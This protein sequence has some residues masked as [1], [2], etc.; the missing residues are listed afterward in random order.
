MGRRWPLTV[1]PGPLPVFEWLI[2][3]LPSSL[4][5][6][7]GIECCTEQQGVTRTSRSLGGMLSKPSLGDGTDG[8]QQ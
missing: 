4:H 6:K 1:F 3:L 2:G 5:I 7:G 8:S